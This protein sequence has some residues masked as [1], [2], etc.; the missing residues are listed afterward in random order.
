MILIGIIRIKFVAVLLG[1]TGLG[2]IKLLNAPI[3]LIISITGLGISISAVRDISEAQGSNDQRR[4]SIAIKTLLRWSWFAGI[5]GAMITI[6]LSTQLSQWAFG[7]QDYSWAFIWLSITLLVEALRKGQIAQM[8]GMRKLY[9][10][11]RASVIGSALGLCVAVPLYYIYGLKGIVPAMILTP[12][13][14]LAV[15]W[16]F[17]RK[18]KTE[19]VKQKFKES[20]IAG[21]GMAKLGMYI[22]LTGFM[23]SASTYILNIYIR[24]WGGIDQVGLYNAGWG[25]IAQYTGMI[26]TAMATDYFP[27]LSAIN[28]DIEK[29]KNLVRQQAETALFIMSPLLV[30]AII[31]MPQFIRLL[32][33][34]SFLPVV[35]FANI[36]ILSMPFK[37][38]SWSMGYLYIA[39]NDGRLFFFIE[40]FGGLLFLGFN[41]LGYYFLKLEGLGISFILAYLIGIT[42]NYL[43]LYHRYRF[44]LPESFLYLFILIYFFI[45]TAFAT[46][47]ISDNILRYLSGIIILIAS[48]AFSLYQLNRVMDIKSILPGIFNRFRRK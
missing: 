41:L 7:N 1:T 9:D 38:V 30:L 44:K 16:Y 20:Y 13:A 32:Y 12:A 3:E 26:F 25:V 46:S 2:I 23:A 18:I 37:A 33:T 47:L 39:R 42:T 35:L 43:I 22:T 15:S 6:V 27:R 11:A 17:A 29:V 8:Q 28:A 31:A 48:S 21:L 24:K 4:I 10:M 40:L 5:L 14:G 34:P 45:A 19:N 36:T